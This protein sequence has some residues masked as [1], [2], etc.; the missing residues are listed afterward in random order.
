M[1]TAR[2]PTPARGMTLIELVVVMA[3]LG[4]LLVEVIPDIGV[5]MKNTQIRNAAESIEVGIEQARIEAVRR[6]HNVQFSLVSL[7]NIAVMD[8]SCAQSSTAPSWV[9]SLDVPDGACGAAATASPFVIATHPAGDGAKNATVVATQSDGTPA[10]SLTFDALG[11]VVSTASIA[12]VVVSYSPGTADLRPL[13]VLVTGS[14][15]VR[16][17]DPNVSSSS[18]PRKC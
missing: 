6:N 4:L 1:N 3:I 16:T 14:G 12:Q 13:T 11:R 7:A 10:T 18:D 2:T 9:V 8:N 5:W 17:C 15:N